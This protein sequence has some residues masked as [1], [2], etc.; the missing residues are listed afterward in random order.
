MSEKRFTLC[1]DDFSN[2]EIR[3]RD[4]VFHFLWEV[5][6]ILNEQ[7]AEIDDLKEENRQLA[8]RVALFEA[9]TSEYF[10]KLSKAKQWKGNNAKL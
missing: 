6:P 8:A 2:Y 3:D 4:K 9:I 7:Q 5:A 1:Q 10:V